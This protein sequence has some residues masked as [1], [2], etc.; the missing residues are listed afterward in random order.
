MG[1]ISTK[2]SIK[3]LNPIN[4]AF[5]IFDTLYVVF[6]NFYICDKIIMLVWTQVQEGRDK[7][8]IYKWEEL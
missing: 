3:S 7:G 5:L 6:P 1:N 2:F 8:S 4:G